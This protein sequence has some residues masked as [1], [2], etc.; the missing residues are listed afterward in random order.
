MFLLKTAS[1]FGLG[2]RTA[3]VFCMVVLIS[4]MELC[5]VW[6]QSDHKFF[7]F[8]YGSTIVIREVGA[9]EL[10]VLTGNADPIRYTS[11]AYITAWKL[12][13]IDELNRYLDLQRSMR[14]RKP[15]EI[16]DKKSAHFVVD[17]ASESHFDCFGKRLGWIPNDSESGN[18]DAS[19]V[20][21]RIAVAEL[22]EWRIQ[23]AFSSKNFLSVDEYTKQFE[24]KRSESSR[25]KLEG[26]K[27]RQFRSKQLN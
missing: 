6:A 23:P 3:F 10:I 2:V 22:F 21:G 27:P 11:R 12:D 17:L 7:G 1:K 16:D 25:K 4:S 20:N 9:E 13:S 19:F 8:F 26:E 24:S 14:F 18:I 5:A 15:T